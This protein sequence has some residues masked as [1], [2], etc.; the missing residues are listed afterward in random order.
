MGKEGKF[1]Y[2]EN[3]SLDDLKYTHDILI[4]NYKDFRLSQLAYRIKSQVTY[5]PKPKMFYC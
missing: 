3:P 4:C 1:N 2:C 5:R